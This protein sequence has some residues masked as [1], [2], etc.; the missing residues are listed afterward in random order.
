MPLRQL[1]SLYENRKH[2]LTE[3]LRSDKK[4][5]VARR[6]QMN[7]AIAEIDGLLKA[8]ETLREQ[9]IYDN[10]KLDAKTSLNLNK[11]LFNRINER[12]QTRFDNS[13]TKKNLMLLFLKKSETTA[14]YEL[15]SKIAKTEGY[16]SIGH[17]FRE[18][19]ENEREHSKIIFKH[20]HWD[21]KTKENILES[22][23]IERQCHDKMYKEFEDTARKEKFNEI[24][25]FIKELSEIDAEHEKKL[26][27]MLKI[28]HDNKLF[29]SENVV[30]WKC[31]NCGHMSD[32]KEAPKKCKVCKKTQ[33]FFEIHKE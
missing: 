20:L 28:M 13:E 9:E 26:L 12:L 14:R 31:R 29:N 4:L 24:A 7:G 2:T 25:E 5:T 16:E 11:G 1:K 10:Q 32:G 22:A 21:R 3:T 30:R 27:K 19:A 6:E 18:F 33:A 17:L 23:D 8:I 15:Y